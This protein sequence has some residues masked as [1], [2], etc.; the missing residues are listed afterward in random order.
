MEEERMLPRFRSMG[1]VLCLAT[2]VIVGVVTAR[3]RQRGGQE[4]SDRTSHIDADI[5]R[6][7]IMRRIQ[8]QLGASDTEWQVIQP[9]LQKLMELSRRADGR[10]PG[11]GTQGP[12][13][14][15]RRPSTG[16][17]REPSSVQE[18]LDDLRTL[19]S[20]ANAR[21]EQ[22]NAKL[23]TLRKAK[24]IAKQRRAQARIELRLVLNVHQEARLVLM[25]LL[26]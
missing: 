16:T 1:V 14:R 8:Q 5:K 2:L 9:R 4:T 11:Q 23:A 3:S 7:Q 19:M 25:G 17:S 24:E 10:A 6:S 15:A 20:D 26:E 13:G 21:S 22:V 12:R 18:A